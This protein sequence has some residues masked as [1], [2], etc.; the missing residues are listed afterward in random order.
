M[1]KNLIFYVNG[2]FVSKDKARVSILDLGLIR[3]YGVFDFLRTYNGKPFKLD[4]HLKRLQ[5]SAKQIGL[6]CPPIS[7]IKQMT[8]KTLAKNNLPEAN[9][10]I[11]LTGGVSLDQ[12]T[13]A[14]KPTL[15]VIIT[16]AISF[17]VAYY[18]KGIKVVTVP[19]GRSYHLAKTINYIPAILA[20]KIAKKK[21]A[22]EA[23][24]TN[25]RGEVLE[26]TTSSFFIFKNGNLITPQDEIL[27]GITRQVVIDLAKK[28]FK[29]VFRPIKYQELEEID[30][31]FI[32]ASNKEVMPV[33]QI[34]NLTVGNGRVGEN[35][36]RIMELFHD[37]SRGARNK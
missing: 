11:L 15:A 19:F 4:E 24:Y 8:I 16:P 13:P 28:E 10:K 35:T 36:K 12:I 9:I 5:N 6:E 34:D 7:Q 37:F 33:V 20:L 27:K 18:E 32:T 31:A 25:K 21:K 26:G 1:S 17:P 2:K 23:L 14:D 30:E 22:I 3:G 29:T